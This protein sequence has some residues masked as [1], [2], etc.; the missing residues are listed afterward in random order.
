MIEVQVS[1]DILIKSA[2]RAK[3]MGRLKNSITE[4]QGNLSGFVGE[5]VVSDYY[6]FTIK[7]TYDYDLVTKGG[8][9]VDVKTKRT[10]VKPKPHYECS[11]GAFNTKQKCDIYFFV[12]VSNDLKTAWILGYKMKE[13][14]FKRAKLLKKGDIDPD[15]SF[16]VKADCYN[17]PI[18]ELDQIPCLEYK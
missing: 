4:G 18:S 12:R 13:E 17:L 15:N 10:I 1:E 2:N 6:G 3:E 9:K 5:Q 8:K 7:N 11:I 16:T 14:Y